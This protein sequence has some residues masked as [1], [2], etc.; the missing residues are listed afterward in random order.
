MK[1]RSNVHAFTLIE[2]MVVI[3]II[4]ILATVAT[5]AYKNYVLRSKMAE[6]YVGL[7]AMKKAQ[8]TYFHT[9]GHFF[10]FGDGGATHVLPFKG[11]KAAW[12]GTDD[13]SP[14]TRL[15]VMIEDSYFSYTAYAG[16]Y[17]ADGNPMTSAYQYAPNPQGEFMPEAGNPIDRLEGGMLFKGPGDGGPAGCFDST[18]GISSGDLGIQG[19]PGEHFFVSLAGSNFKSEPASVCTIFMQA[20]RAYDGE[21]I[22]TPPISLNYGE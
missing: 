16:F 18:S 8:I 22:Q 13:V 2:L 9:N 15:K 11:K 14:N 20:V 4:G 19:L 6:A 21:I 17:D 12:F 10:D 1:K 7:D 3:V 5:P